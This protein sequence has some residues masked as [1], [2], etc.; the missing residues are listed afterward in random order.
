[1]TELDVVFT[2]LT[3][4]VVVLLWAAAVAFGRDSR[5]GGEWRVTPNLRDRVPRLGD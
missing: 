1:V 2:A 5:K 3:V 4:L